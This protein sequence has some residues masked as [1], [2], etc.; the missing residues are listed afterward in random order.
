MQ[1]SAERSVDCSAAE[2]M[3]RQ[4]L[5]ATGTDSLTPSALSTEAFPPRQHSTLSTEAPGLRQ[6]PTLSTEALGLRQHPT[7]STE[8]PGLRQHSVI[9]T[10][11]LGLHQNSVIS[12]GGRRPEWRDP[13]ISDHLRSPDPASSL[14][15]AAAARVAA[16]RNRR[17]GAHAIEAAR[18][19]AL[20]LERAQIDRDARRG[21]SRV[22]DTVRARYEHS[23]SYRDFLAAEAE[24][25]TQQARAEA[26]IA[27]RNARAIA[28][29]QLQLLEELRHQTGLATRDSI[30]DRHPERTAQQEAASAPHPNSVI[31]TEASA[32]HPN[33]VI[34]TG[35]R[36][37]EWRDLHLGSPQIPE[38]HPNPVIPTEASAP[39]PNPV[40]STGG[41]RP[42]WRDL[43]LGSPQIPEPHPNPVIPTAASAPHPNPVISTG[44]RRPEWRD[45]CISEA[46]AHHKPQTASGDLFA[47]QFANTPA[48]ET[49]TDG[50]TV[51]L[52][53]D[54]GP[55]G[56]TPP[57]LS[58][59]YADAGGTVTELEDLE[60]EIAFRRAPEF[61][62]HIIETLPLPTN[63]IE[64][65]RELVAARRARPRLA[66]GPL[67]E[68]LTP[69]PQ[70]RIFEVEPE[71]I[72]TEPAAPQE[73]ATAAPGWQ[74]LLL[75][76]PAIRL[77]H[78]RPQAG[79]AAPLDDIAPISRRLM[80]STVDAC[81]IGAA[82][83]A[84]ATI[85]AW[86]SGP[87]LQALSQPGF[88][89]PLAAAVFL[90]LAIAALLYQ[91][92]FF[93]LNE[94][95]P[96]MRYARIALCTFADA[97][98]TRRQMRRRVLA[99]VLAACPL[100]LGLL[101]AWMDDDRLGWHDRISRMYHRSY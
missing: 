97:N 100:G 8:A 17:A 74:G 93:S 73:T 72:S 79:N 65:P 18:E 86:I 85:V 66:E 101:W 59:Y 34:S 20:R 44:G 88:R 71:T 95:T 53:D 49:T 2:E 96:G 76:T 62:D 99:T 92:L 40:I 23:Q 25:A 15:E 33:P 38:P 54:L 46:S 81:C 39:H 56:P 21:V 29:A 98:P 3:A 84:F 16:H 50:L 35:G 91:L 32:P 28:D 43:H 55:F 4:N 26:E 31:S 87:R 77:A 7:L 27:A 1:G 48:T 60:Q 83:I 45:P 22:R 5:L 70:L 47:D 63:L 78:M 69:Q 61:T 10:E 90:T 67:R 51:R 37:P 68:E 42:E 58:A 80:A 94:A 64:F 57:S 13:C 11:A 82:F 52:Y 36:R 19:E 12:T 89:I 75:D 14:R 6:H 9:S 30:D 41:R 24:R